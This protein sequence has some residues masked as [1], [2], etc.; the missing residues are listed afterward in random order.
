MGK[1]RE[2]FEL[3]DKFSATFTKYIQLGNDATASTRA[4]RD[5]ATRATAAARVQSAAM[6]AA[7]ASSRAESAA[8]RLTVSQSIFFSI[9]ETYCT[10]ST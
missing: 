1:I 2:V 4:L 9:C 10:L 5:A 7:A 8:Y 3:E 6:N